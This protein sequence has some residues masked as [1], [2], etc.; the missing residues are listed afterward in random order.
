MKES[1]KVGSYLLR[2]KSTKTLSQRIDRSY[3]K[4]SAPLRRW[5]IVL[6]SFC[7]SLGLAW[8]GINAL[9]RNQSPYM[10]GELTTPH[11]FLTKGCDTCHGGNIGVA[12][13]VTDRAC[14]SCHDA[15]S[16]SAR[17][18]AIPGCG[19]CHAEH[20]GLLR[21]DGH[22]DQE[23]LKCHSD[24]R[25]KTGAP[26]ADAHI[27][28]FSS[29]PQFAAVSTGHDPVGIKF[30]HAKHVG[31]LSQ[32]CGDCH[33]PAD[34]S[35]QRE[36]ILGRRRV[37]SRALMRIPTYAGTCMPCHALNFDDKIPDPAPHAS[38]AEVDRF[39]R[40]SLTKYIAA[41]PDDLGKEGAPGNQPAWVN[42][43][44]ETDEKQLWSVTCEH[45]HAMGQAESS[46][47]PVVPPAK[48]TA[49]WFP[50][51]SF[52][53]AAHEELTCASCHPDAAKSASS[54]DLLLPGIAV[55]KN[56]HNSGKA[57]SGNTCATCHRYHDWSNG[58][59][60]EGKFRI[61]DL[62]LM[63]TPRRVTAF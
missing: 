37:S 50:K 53:H 17:Q 48:V 35:A 28:S 43:R 47:L 24:L 21:L 2:D 42:L 61:K 59:G 3:L 4:R 60:F 6:T 25:T 9:A 62:T 44:A 52:D 30:N 11:S 29:H 8:L 13:H 31:E 7:V 26:T 20:R 5:R 58:K 46:G 54:S 39:V 33:P 16:H 1:S 63:Q 12:K 56:C 23:C 18:V 14:M 34:R 49:H 19:E 38:A 22:Y 51:A 55:C 27:D 10:P 36:N 15:P 57:W 45:C 32:K 40:E 41:H